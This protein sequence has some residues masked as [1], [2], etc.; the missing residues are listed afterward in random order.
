MTSCIE[1]GFDYD[2]SFLWP[3][4]T[5]NTYPYFWFI[6]YK[7]STKLG[8]KSLLN[9]PRGGGQK[10]LR[11]GKNLIIL[12]LIALRAIFVYFVS[13]V[14]FL[15][16]FVPNSW[17][18]SFVPKKYRPLPWLKSC[19]CAWIVY[20]LSIN[21]QQVGEH[22]HVMLEINQSHVKNKWDR[23]YITLKGV[24]VGSIYGG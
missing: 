6:Q 5:I 15:L 4:F 3:K 23:G 22:C 16:S 18:K 14:P 24:Y 8:T 2:Q 21:T 10:P 17:K 11:G 13:F 9:L 1:A 19:I 20:I 7:N 12:H